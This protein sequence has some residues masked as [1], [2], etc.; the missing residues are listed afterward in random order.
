[1]I[2]FPF[3]LGGLGWAVCLLLWAVVAWLAYL[4]IRW[5]N[6]KL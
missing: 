2:E 5:F 4:A 1:M 6:N 3:W